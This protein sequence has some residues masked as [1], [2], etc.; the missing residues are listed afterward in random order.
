MEQG[1]PRNEQPVEEIEGIEDE[2]YGW[3]FHRW[4]FGIALVVTLLLYGL[5]W[6]FVEPTPP[7]ID[8]TKLPPPP[9]SF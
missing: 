4:P 8:P 3:N 1:E 5:I 7:Y 2:A 9:G 6:L